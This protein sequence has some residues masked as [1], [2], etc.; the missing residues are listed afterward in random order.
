MFQDISKQTEPYRQ[1]LD[2]PHLPRLH[3]PNH[4]RYQVRTGEREQPNLGW[5]G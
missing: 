5:E 4:H 3:I 2:P 1:K